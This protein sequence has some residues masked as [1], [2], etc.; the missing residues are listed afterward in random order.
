MLVAFVGLLGCATAG[1]SG[2]HGVLVP[3]PSRCELMDL[4]RAGQTVSSLERAEEL[5]CPALV[6]GVDLGRWRVVLFPA[7]HY[8][9]RWGRA[10]RVDDATTDVEIVITEQCGGPAPRPLLLVGR[11]PADGTEVVFRRIDE[12]SELCERVRRG[13]VPPPP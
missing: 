11:V 8:T 7:P 13:E 9:A 1:T 5:G 4:P 10:R 2:E 12:P 6:D 3:T